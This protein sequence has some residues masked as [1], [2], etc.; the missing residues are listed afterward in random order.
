[1]LEGCSLLCLKEILSGSVVVFK[2]SCLLAENVLKD[3]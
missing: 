1:M 3:Y 2:S